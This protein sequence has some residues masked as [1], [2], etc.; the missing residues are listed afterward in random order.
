MSNVM[1]PVSSRPKM[2]EGYGVPKNEE[3]LL[4]WSYVVERMTTARNYWI[5]TARPD[6]TPH[7]VPVWG[8][9]LDN[10]LYFDT[11]PA[12]RTGR[13]FKLNPAATV[14]LESGDEVVIIDGRIEGMS[15]QTVLKRLR[16]LYKIKYEGKKESDFADQDDKAAEPDHGMF[17]LRPQVVLA[18]RDFFS[19]ATRW[20]FE[21]GKS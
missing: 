1:V 12:T 5:V 20:R 21:A 6:G 19:T 4:P 15:D 7:A 9:W 18:W 3:G 13:N 14:H 8:V 16:R 2:P 10:A 17:V 11:D